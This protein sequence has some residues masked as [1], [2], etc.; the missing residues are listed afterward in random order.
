MALADILFMSDTDTFPLPLVVGSIV[1]LDNTPVKQVPMPAVWPPVVPVAPIV[2]PVI[3]VPQLQLPDQYTGYIQE[4]FGH[5]IVV[6]ISPLILVSENANMRWSKNI[7]ITQFNVIGTA[8]PDALTL[9]MT[10][11]SA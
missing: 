4:R 3:P 2:P 11:L 10:R 9:C 1:Q 5:A 7:D 6:S 8:K